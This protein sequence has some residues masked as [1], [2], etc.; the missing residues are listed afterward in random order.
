MSTSHSLKSITKDMI[1]HVFTFLVTVDTLSFYNTHKNNDHSI[2][3]LR[4][5]REYN[6]YP[7]YLAVYVK[8]YIQDAYVTWRPTR[9]LL[10]MLNQFNTYACD[11][12]EMYSDIWFKGLNY[13]NNHRKCFGSGI[14]WTEYKRKTR[15]N[16]E[17]AETA[18]EMVWLPKMIQM[19]LNEWINLQSRKSARYYMINWV[20]LCFDIQVNAVHKSNGYTTNLGYKTTLPN[21]LL[22]PM[23]NKILK[24]ENSVYKRSREKRVVCERL[25]DLEWGYR[26]T[27]WYDMNENNVSRYQRYQSEYDYDDKFDIQWDRKNKSERWTYM[28]GKESHRAKHH[29]AK[30]HKKG[31]YGIRHGDNRCRVK[32]RGMVW[33]DWDTAVLKKPK[34]YSS[35]AAVVKNI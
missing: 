16:K 30:W 33:C 20:V 22:K 4:Q 17:K 15:V 25:S 9:K 28:Y 7:A 19:I 8:H 1:L 23:W 32:S 12:K 2:A 27:M 14:N 21:K 26:L 24:Y 10:E 35:W 18:L 29:N 34:R 31:R 5:R 3:I 13:D 6:Y 11:I